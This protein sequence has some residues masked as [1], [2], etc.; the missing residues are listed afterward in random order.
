MSSGQ[1]FQA[2]LNSLR[3]GRISF[4]QA[5]T[6]GVELVHHFDS[7]EHPIFHTADG[8][9]V[10]RDAITEEWSVIEGGRNGSPVRSGELD[11]VHQP[12]VAADARIH[13]T[14]TVDETATV[15]PGATIG[16]YAHVGAHAHVGK[17]STIASF[18]RVEGG[19]FVGAFTSV[20][21]GSRIGPG[22]IIGA[23]SRIG[24]T[25][26]IGAGARLE[27]RTHID[28][29]DNIAAHTRTGTA[30]RPGSRLQPGQVTHLVDRLAALDRD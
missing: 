26:N 28:A 20:H 21:D 5:A 19:A 30:R 14:A 29:F 23:G 7:N 2:H 11:R 25:S 27:Q 3:A 1:H 17:D 9:I 13:E 8:D 6:L 12:Y 24:P 18:T 22:A 15:E 16:P 10:H 4:E